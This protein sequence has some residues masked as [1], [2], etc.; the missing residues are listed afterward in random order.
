MSEEWLVD[1]Y[2]LLH[3]AYPS[4]SS[5]RIKPDREAFLAELAGFSALDGK[6]MLVVLDGAGDQAELDKHT[7]PKF[8]V[9]YSQ[10]VSADACI[11][12]TLFERRTEARFTVVTD[13]RAISNIARGSGALVMGAAGFLERL[14]ESRKERADKQAHDKMKGH[15]FNRPFDK[16]KDL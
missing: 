13:D 10:K 16:L 9:I 1:G 8:R 2:N 6:P 5:T 3:A 14:K 7:A 4:G 11:E 12:R 15:G